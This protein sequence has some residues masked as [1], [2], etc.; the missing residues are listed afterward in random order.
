MKATPRE[1]APGT[2]TGPGELRIERWLPGPA[3]RLWS[4]LTESEK[5]GLWLAPGSME[6]R[7]GGRVEL[8]FR[9]AD[10]SHEKEYPPQFGEMSDGHTILGTVTLWDPPRRLGY[11]WGEETYDTEVEFE[12]VPQGEEVLLV[13]THRRLR[14]RPALFSVA[15]GWDAHLGILADRLA[16][17][18]PRGFWSTHER[19]ER[20]YAERL[21]DAAVAPP[22]P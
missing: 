22:V 14:S 20:G 21:A 12:L 16:D 7:V 17:R 13:V 4:W 2:S 6:P 9:H 3:E 8:H 11:T 10:L 15:A 1:E 19:L 18:E 5:R